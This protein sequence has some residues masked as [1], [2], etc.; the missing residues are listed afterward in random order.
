MS[1]PVVFVSGSA[2]LSVV[3]VFR[4]A[5]VAGIAFRSHR[6][7]L[8]VSLGVPLA[9]P[10]RFVFRLVHVG[11][12]GGAPFLLARFL[13][14][15]CHERAFPV[16][17]SFSFRF[18][19]SLGRAVW[20]FVRSVV[21]PV[22]SPVGSLCVSGFLRLV[23]RLVERLVLS[24]CSPCRQHLPCSSSLVEDGPVS[25][26]RGYRAWRFVEVIGPVACFLLYPY[27]RRFPQLIFSSWRGRGLSRSSLGRG[28]GILVP[29]RHRFS[30]CLASPVG[31]YR[32]PVRRP[33]CLPD[34]ASRS[35][36]SCSL[37]LSASSG[38]SRSQGVFSRSP[39]SARAVFV[40]S[41]SHLFSI[42]I[43][44]GRR[45]NEQIDGTSWACRFIW[46]I[47]GTQ[48]EQRPGSMRRNGGN[49]DE[50]E[51]TSE[52]SEATGA[53]HKRRRL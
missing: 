13:V 36:A 11:S 32:R 5:L 2:Q 51:R 29:M 30:H 7:P 28:V 9:V 46:G 6:F 22:V 38:A 40:S 12:W 45:P 48:M 16:A 3:L 35:L 37:P 42:A 52:V 18:V 25:S 31:S 8:F 19:V 21:S 20:R 33:V 34:G 43:I 41:I 1:R 24:S 39:P 17:S 26:Y 23:G 15:S 10:F 47:G 50:D 44:V 49:D 14:S 4:R 27:T 53:R